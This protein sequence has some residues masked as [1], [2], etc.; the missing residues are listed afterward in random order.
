MYK[1]TT[2]IFTN[3]VKPHPLGLYLDF[4]GQQMVLP[5]S[6]FYYWI[7]VVPIDFSPLVSLLQ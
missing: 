3:N 5:E 4:V 1:T 6:S 7:V 2:I